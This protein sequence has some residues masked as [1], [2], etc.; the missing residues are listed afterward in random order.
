[1]NETVKAYRAEGELNYILGHPSV[2]NDTQISQVAYQAITKN[3]KEET[4]VKFEKVTGGEDFSFYLQEI[5]G[6][7]AFIGVRNESKDV[8]YPHHHKNFNIDENALIFG[9]TLYSQFAL[10][11]L[12]QF[13]C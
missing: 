6:I 1:M 8:I 3:F 2:I 11:Y 4:I 7:M 13:K 5:P 10:D 12:R 9:T